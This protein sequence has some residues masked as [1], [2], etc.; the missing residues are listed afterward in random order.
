MLEPER[1]IAHHAAARVAWLRAA[2]LRANGGIVA[3]A[4]L[5]IGVA[6]AANSEGEVL[7]AGLAGLVAGSLALAM[8]EY[9]AAAGTP[10]ADPS[11]CVGGDDDQHPVIHHRRGPADDLGAGPAGGL[12]DYHAGSAL[13]VALTSGAGFAV[14]GALPLAAASAFRLPAMPLGIALVALTGAA[15]CAG[16]GARSA[17][18]VPARCMARAASWTAAAFVAAFAIGRIF[19]AA[20]V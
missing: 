18:L 14:G 19:G 20:M 3:I 16:L 15:V 13:Q 1:M 4:A 9:A 11:L 10:V 5:L 17:G 6:A 12:D 7:L 2:A 8:G